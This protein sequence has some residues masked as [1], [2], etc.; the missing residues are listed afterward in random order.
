L[1]WDDWVGYK[2]L[3]GELVADGAEAGDVQRPVAAAA[4]EAAEVVWRAAARQPAATARTPA[5]VRPP[6]GG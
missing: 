6:L 5:R 4:G 3:K 2:G 1:G